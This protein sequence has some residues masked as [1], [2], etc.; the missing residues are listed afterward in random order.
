MH[1]VLV[2]PASTLLS[3]ISIDITISS[4]L[5]P[6][7]AAPSQ[8]VSN[9]SCTGVTCNAAQGHWWPVFDLDPAETYIVSAN[10]WPELNQAA[11]YL[12]Q[13]LTSQGR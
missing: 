11:F 2:A 3:E 8:A 6:N 1:A 5:A 4:S 9:S 10:Q 12:T 7:G 13:A